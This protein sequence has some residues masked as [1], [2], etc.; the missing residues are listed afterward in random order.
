MDRCGR[1]RRPLSKFSQ[2]SPLLDE[3]SLLE[4]E[5][6]MTMMLFIPLRQGSVNKAGFDKLAIAASGVAA[7]GFLILK[8]CPL[9]QDA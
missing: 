3:K 5:S 6:M 2:K 7:V 1:E 4:M 9:P 8:K